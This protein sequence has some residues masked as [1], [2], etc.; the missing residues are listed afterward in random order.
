VTRRRVTRRREGPPPRHGAANVASHARRA[1]ALRLG[2]EDKLRVV[3]AEAPKAAP[4]ATRSRHE[5]TS[6]TTMA[7]LATG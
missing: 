6:V 7:S 2:C 3:P 1:E 5:M 4:S